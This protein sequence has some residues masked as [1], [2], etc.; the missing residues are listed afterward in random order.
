LKIQLRLGYSKVPWQRTIVLVHYLPAAAMI[1]SQEQDWN[2]LIS[3]VNANAICGEHA[4]A[5]GST[6]SSS[7]RQ[8]EIR[9]H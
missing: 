6:T 9:H 7:T 5:A 3:I 4:H 2:C 8:I 1:V